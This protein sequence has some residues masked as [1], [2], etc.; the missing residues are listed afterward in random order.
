LE[1]K[2]VTDVSDRDEVIAE[3]V[4]AAGSIGRLA[5]DRDAF[6]QALEGFRGEDA[7]AFHAA[8]ERLDLVPFCRP[9][10]DWLCSKDCVIRCLQLAGPPPKSFAE[11][12]DPGEFADVVARITGEETTLRRLVE[13]VERQDVG[14]FQA[15]VDELEV[16][17]FRH[18]LCHWVCR[19]RCELVCRWVCGRELPRP[20]L[21]DELR[22]AGDSIRRLAASSRAMAEAVRAVRV[23]DCPGL[24]RVLAGVGLSDR[25]FQIC[26]WFCSWRCLLVCLTVCRPF[27]DA[28]P[29][30]SDAEILAFAEATGRLA[31]QPEVVADLI[32]AMDRLDEKAFGEL[33][34][35]LELQR[36][37]LQLCHW[38]CYL[39]CERFC[40]CVCPPLLGRI[41]T[42]TEGSCAS[43][44]PVP[45]CSTGAGPL[46]GIEVTGAAGGGG[47][48][49]YTLRYSWGGN[50]PVNTA[51]VYPDCSRPP[52][53]AASSVPVLGG[54][55]GWLDVTL[56]PPGITSF[57]VYLDVFDSGAGQVSDTATFE[58]QTR[59]VEITA[60][61]K[62]NALDGPDPFHPLSVIRLIKDVNDPSLL[63]PEQS[64]GGAF[65]VDGSAY[66][67]GCDRIISQFVLARFDAPP[68]A[69]LPTP[70]DATGGTPLIAAVPYEDI[71]SH[72][73]QSG[74]FPVTTPNTI[75]NGDLVAFWSA[76]NCTFLGSPY[77]VPKVRPVPFWVSNPLSGR[78]L[79]LLEV[80]D[81][82]LPAGGFP[83]TVAAKDQVAVWIDNHI[84]TA[85]I[86]SIG[87]VTGCGDLLLKPFVGTTAEIRGVAWDP[88]IDSSAPQQRP[89]D[90]FG[91]Y[92]LDYKKDG[93]TSSTGIPG[94][95]P[96]TRV[97][98]VWPGPPPP[99][100][101][102]VLA[103]WDV[104]GAL[105]YTGPPP[106]PAGKLARGERCAFVI[107]L[108][109]TD[110]THVGDSGSHNTA[111]PFTYALTVINDI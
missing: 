36:F 41:D 58:V 97:P 62:V 86:T 18:L 46:I 40:L 98:N 39:Q 19:V 108:T 96:N 50:P 103:H 95:T 89:N 4:E 6:Q 84:P 30:T 9:V 79:I 20:D 56:L 1:E 45:A 29:D 59:A 111:G 77:T 93:E 2:P 99:G 48:D 106:T 66:L 78:F 49:H 53:N 101:D 75:L 13:V 70:P 67:I 10:C 32:T 51:V 3:A 82:P 5:A 26:F 42:P 21:F 27:L 14:G 102:G 69:A 105:D 63:V 85:T 33:V 80:R 61:A 15:L 12:P 68:A 31:G 71:P 81:R 57:T 72:P 52:A 76:S 92:S 24:Q 22:R 91:S 17:R 90:N 28:Q 83:G 109:V 7:D 73:W 87:G 25:C 11:V 60:V 55:L 107:S 88:P 16:R 44:S 34:R 74:C 23:G 35:R 64:V 104:V 37:C 8:L 54:T 47:F 100:A 43:S 65:S 94:A 38:L 110:T